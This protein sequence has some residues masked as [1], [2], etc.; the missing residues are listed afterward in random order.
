[1]RLIATLDNEKYARKFSTYLSSESIDNK[2]EITINTDW[3]S[4]DYGKVTCY[5]WVISEEQTDDAIELLEQFQNNPED[6]RFEVEPNI[7]LIEKNGSESNGANKD[8]NEWIHV[9][10]PPTP[11][12]R[13]EPLGIVT[14]YILIACCTLFLL[15][16]VASPPV[17]LP[18][19]P[20]LP[21]A[22]LYLS[23]FNKTLLYDWP[24][25]YEIVEKL[26]NAYGID[27]LRNPENLPPAGKFLLNEYEHTPYWRGFYEK[28]VAYFKD[29]K[30][31]ITIDAPMFEKIRE[32]EWWRLFSP[33]L[34]HA[35]FLHIFFNMMWLIVLG[36][37]I[38]ERMSK[39][40]YILFILIIGILSNTAQYLMS[41]P[42]FIGFS[43]V[44]V[45]MITFIWERQRRSAWE[46]YQLLPATVLMIALVIIGI[47]GIQLVSFIL[48]IQKFGPITPGIANTAHLTGGLV[49]YI[50]GRL[51][52][53]AHKQ[54]KP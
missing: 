39:G 8:A 53:F 50:L 27:L 51:E 20:K 9:E 43:G 38:E 17:S 19:P 13:N 24:K 22:P 5:L 41:G 36:K 18:P 31:G 15:D 3:G 6:A 52:F 23:P 4:S 32:G 54:L 16:I 12:R 49:G 44:L 2:L 21:V 47:F 40:R 25:A 30:V 42:D 1:M 11:K 48:E 10:K 46:G 14:L 7:P 33:A 37:Q 34:L 45:G 28:F 26:K 35:N 29:P